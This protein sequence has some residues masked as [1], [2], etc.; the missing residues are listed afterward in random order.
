MRTNERD[1]YGTAAEAIRRH[2]D[3]SNEFFA[4][5]LDPSMTYSCPL[6]EL[7]DDLEAGQARKVDH[8]AIHAR[9]VGAARVLDIGC[10]WGGTLHRLVTHHQVRHAVGLTLSP[11]QQTHVRAAGEPRVDVRLENWQ[12]HRPGAPYDA[13]VSIEAFEHFAGRAGHRS[14]RVAGY[15]H[16][17]ATCHQ[18]LAPDGRLSLQTSARAEDITERRELAESAFILNTIFPDTQ[19]PAFDEIVE[20]GDP[21]F[22]LVAHRADPDQYARACAAW[23]DRLRRHRAAAADLVGERTV[24]HYERY[25]AIC[26]EHFTA[27]YLTL[28]RLTFQRRRTVRG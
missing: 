24:N 15:R 11:A 21:Y 20:A 1:R 5:W 22:H 13:I 7:D 17:F 19:I 8:H 4:L 16:F 2:Y 10:G 18:W 23:L 25:L 26:T 14:A 6:W 28:L 9:A 12:D 27:G 3:V